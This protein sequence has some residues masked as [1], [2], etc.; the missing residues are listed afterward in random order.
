[1]RY[2][3]LDTLQKGPA[4]RIIGRETALHMVT[5]VGVYFPSMSQKRYIAHWSFSEF[6]FYKDEH[7]TEK[8]HSLTVEKAFFPT[9]IF[10]PLVLDQEMFSFLIWFPLDPLKQRTILSITLKKNNTLI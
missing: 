2:D 1:M 10:L 4:G 7:F 6:M 3:H 8:E 9:E 5:F